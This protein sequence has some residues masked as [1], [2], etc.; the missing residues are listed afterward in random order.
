[1]RRASV[2]FVNSLSLLERGLQMLK[3]SLAQLLLYPCL[4]VRSN[5]KYTI[6]CTVNY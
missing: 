6:K 4:I 2:P 1:M 3:C 5:C